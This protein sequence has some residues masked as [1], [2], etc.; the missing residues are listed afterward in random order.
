MATFRSGDLS[1][2]YDD[3]QPAGE[4]AGT[5]FLVHGFATSRAENWRRL[6]WYGAFERKNY[7][8]VALDLRGHGESDK[9][10]DPSAYGGDVLVGDIV[11]L[12]DHLSLGRVDLLGYSMGSRL[13]LQTAIEHP[14]RIANLIVGG[15][16]E[17]MLKPPPAEAPK[18]TMAEAMRAADPESIPDKT[19]KGFRL[20]ADQQGEDRLA[21]A[22][23]TEGRAGAALGPDDL[24]G[25]RAPT[26][27]VAGSRDELAGDPQALANAIP[28]AKSVTLPACDHFSAIPHALFKAAVFDF[29]EGWME[30]E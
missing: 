19:M 15:V 1:L 18:M 9:P 14:E 28:G 22:A 24:L 26:L 12:M 7:R 23:F 17:R 13:S 3:I 21:L 4:A 2:A 10:H 8:L 6:G 5:V 27:V 30:L 11:A 25:V 16:G 29:L 20:F